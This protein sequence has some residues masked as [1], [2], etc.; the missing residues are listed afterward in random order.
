MQ[1]VSA[2]VSKAPVTPVQDEIQ[3]DPTAFYE[4]LTP[5]PPGAV[6]DSRAVL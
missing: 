6:S 2:S 1:K 4:E 3:I 5:S